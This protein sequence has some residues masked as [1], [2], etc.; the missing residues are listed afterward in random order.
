MTE[1]E[2]KPPFE[3]IYDL[4]RLSEA[5]HE[6]TITLGPDDLKSLAEWANVDSVNGFE[7]EV[8]VRRLSQTRF[9]YVARFDATVT[10]SCA[11]TLEPVSSQIIREFT[12][13]LHLVPHV[14]KIIDIGG[15]LGVDDAPEEID[16]PRFD[17][18]APLREELLLAIDPYPRAPG[19][20]F[21]APGAPAAERDNPFAVLKALKG[22]R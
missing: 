14:K 16:N 15:E 1:I 2:L 6:T 9:E 3:R 21:E 22:K 19:V 11:V 5:G 4:N 8:E 10:Q 20:A 12:R 17:L 7:A 13:V 18:A